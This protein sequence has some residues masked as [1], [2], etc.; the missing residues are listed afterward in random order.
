[1]VSPINVL[2]ALQ[3]ADRIVMSAQRGT[4][5]TLYDRPD[6]LRWPGLNLCSSLDWW[7]L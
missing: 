3:T 1:M 7:E 4:R 5:A 2:A 6:H